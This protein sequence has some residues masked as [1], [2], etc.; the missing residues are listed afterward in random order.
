[1]GNRAESLSSKPEE[2]RENA[3]P[4]NAATCRRFCS[5]PTPRHWS[6]SSMETRRQF[7]GDQSGDLS[8]H[9]LEM[10]VFESG[11]VPPHGLN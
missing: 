7:I 9:S 11:P 2:K 5:G 4:W 10:F 6:K 8:T 1:L 3:S